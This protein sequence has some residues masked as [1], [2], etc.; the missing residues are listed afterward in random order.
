MTGSAH[1]RTGLFALLCIVAASSSC[2]GTPA[3]SVAGSSSM[4]DG[5]SRI[6]SG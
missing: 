3:P 5:N 4:P 1:V 2:G 6:F